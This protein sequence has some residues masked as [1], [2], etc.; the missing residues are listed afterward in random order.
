[1]AGMSIRPLGL[2]AMNISQYFGG[3]G[4]NYCQLLYCFTRNIL[5]FGIVKPQFDCFQISTRTAI[6]PDPPTVLVQP[7]GLFLPPKVLTPLSFQLYKGSNLT[8]SIS[9][10]VE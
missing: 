3:I 1:M 2:E 5:M 9:G 7:V 6:V 4:E 10:I 8:G